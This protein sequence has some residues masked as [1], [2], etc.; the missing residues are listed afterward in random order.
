M[1]TINSYK[2]KNEL[3][4][5]TTAFKRVV[6]ITKDKVEGKIDQSLLIEQSEKNLFMKF[7]GIKNSIKDDIK[8]NKFDEALN[9]LIKLREPID[10]FFDNVM[11][12]DKNKHIRNNRLKL[13]SDIKNHFFQIAD[14]T[15]LN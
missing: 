12:M 7:Q 15:K 5:I 10:E 1:K 14:F 2:Q 3:E 6:N 4:H 11:V 13:L 8:N 9:K